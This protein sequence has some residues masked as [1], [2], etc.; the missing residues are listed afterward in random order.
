MIERSPQ[1]RFCL[2]ALLLLPLLSTAARADDAPKTQVNGTLSEIDGVRVLRVWGTPEQRGYANGYLMSSDIA[3]FMNEFFADGSVIDAKGYETRVLRKLHLMTIQPQHE[4]ELRAM[5]AGIEAKA[6]GPVDLPVL[7]RPLQYTDLVAANCMGD[8]LRFGCSSFAAW[9]DMTKD[10]H[11]IAGRNMDW[12]K[13]PAFEGTQLVTVHVPERGSKSLA[14]VSIFWPGL[15]GC[16]TGMNAENVSVAMHDS[17]TPNPSG[18]GGFSSSTMLYREAIE[19]AHAETAIKDISGVLTQRHTLP[20]YNMMVTRPFTGSGPPAVVFEHDADLS[21]SGG[22]TLREPAGSDTHIACTNHS[23]KRYEPHEGTRYPKLCKG[24]DKIVKGNGRSH[25]T[26]KKAWKMLGNV[27]IE[28]IITHHSAVFE[29]NK[30]LM[31]VAFAKRGK[32]APKCKHVTL[33]IAKLIAGDYPG[34]K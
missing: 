18:K 19:A 4:A 23:R 27:P 3:R 34:G 9:G 30:G 6:G 32:N 7:G 26:V 2:C 16:T 24:L 28:G 11:T 29:P 20:G 1:Y 33:D 15:I 5:L 31:H 17:N 10:G 21:N 12:A 8:M 14:W 25:L 13:S 22:L